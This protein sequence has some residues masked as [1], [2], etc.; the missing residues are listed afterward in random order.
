MKNINELIKKDKKRQK[1]AGSKT[2]QG[3]IDFDKLKANNKAIQTLAK[4]LKAQQ[5]KEG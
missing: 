1:K 5:D 2:I 3:L 4:K